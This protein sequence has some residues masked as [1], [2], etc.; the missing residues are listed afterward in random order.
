MKLPFWATFLT[1]LGLVILC[2]LGSWQLQ[3]L[4]WKNDLITQLD[5]AYDNQTSVPIALDKIDQDY[6]YGRVSGRLLTG[7]ALLIGPRTQDKEIG[8]DLIVPLQTNDRTLLVNMGWSNYPLDEMPIYHLQG[9]KVWF[10]GMI[11]TPSWNAF[12]PE[13]DPQNGLWYKLDIDQIAAIKDLKNP[14]PFILRA[15][16]ASH[17]YDTA[18]PNNDRLYP[19]NNHLQYAFFWFAMAGALLVV[20][21]LR[22]LK[23]R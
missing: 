21:V 17:K 23:K 15:E 4:A 5:A 1:I 6:I 2:G 8:H 13:N 7:K 9:K 3:R 19:N 22:F 11:V 18:F 10:E 12:T 14:Y 20:Y 16:A